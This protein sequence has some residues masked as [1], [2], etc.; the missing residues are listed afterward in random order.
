MRAEEGHVLEGERQA[1]RWLKG[2]RRDYFNTGS[3]DST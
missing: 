1:E 2:Y 3:L